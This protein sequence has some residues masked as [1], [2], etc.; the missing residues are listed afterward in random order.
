MKIFV[1]KIKQVSYILASHL[2]QFYTGKVTIVNSESATESDVCSTS[3]LP[4]PYFTIPIY[5][6]W[7]CPWR[8]RKAADLA[9]YPVCCLHPAVWRNVA[10]V[11]KGKGGKD[12][13]YCTEYNFC[14]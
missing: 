5:R 8:V 3:N 1:V 13:K 4:P 12:G 9:R 2:L 6:L 11:G 7:F 10:G 14:V